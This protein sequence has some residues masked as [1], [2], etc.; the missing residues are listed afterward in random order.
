MSRAVVDRVHREFPHLLTWNSHSSCTEFCQRVIAVLNADLGTVDWGHVA[1]SAGEAGH[2]LPN[3]VRV[4]YDVIF[5]KSR[6]LQVDIIE[7]GG[8]HPSIR[9]GPAWGEIDRNVY[10]P[11]NVWTPPQPLF[12]SDAPVTGEIPFTPAALGCGWFCL[13]RALKDWATDA[14]LNFEYI[15]RELNPDYYRVFM[16]LEGQDHDR[17]SGDVWAW[18]GCDI[19]WSSWEDDLKRVLDFVGTRGKKVHATMY[20]GRNHARTLD[21]RKRAH[22]RFV[23]ACNGRWEAIDGVEAANEFNINRFT[24]AEVRDIVRD[25]AAKLPTGMGLAASSP[26]L[27]H[28]LVE[29]GGTWHEA[30]NEEMEESI[31]ELYGGVPVTEMTIHHSRNTGSKWWSPFSYNMFRPDLK[32]RDNEPE[33]PGAS[34][35]GDVSDPVKI[36][37]RYRKTSEA[38]WSHYTP[39][40]RWMVWNGRMPPGYEAYGPEQNVW[41]HP[42]IG[43]IFR[44]LA[45][46]R[47]KAA[48]PGTTP[49]PSTPPPP[50]EWLEPD[51]ILT[52][53]DGVPSQDETTVLLYQLDGNLVVYRDGEAVWQ[54]FT[55]GTSPGQVVMQL[56]GNLVIYD[57]SGMAVWSSGTEGHD[58]ASLLVQNDGNV[59]IYHHDMAIWFTGT[60]R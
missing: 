14:A 28:G 16:D 37:A 8:G 26:A 55:A 54:S 33:G 58:G 42:T 18:A 25:L 21:E 44:G 39:H 52:P 36:V 43:Q 31:N 3:G 49:P 9:G 23:R 53:D 24:A 59:V 15:E 7:S 35:G 6:H 48:G 46:V 50:Q 32:K 1:K 11:S 13:I 34:A 4:S 40:C 56:D 60:A 45:E 29:I 5:S 20:G 47:N 41:D 30:T 17:G 12:V 51:G 27:A 38:Q 22:D 2:T 10:R 19:R 57:A